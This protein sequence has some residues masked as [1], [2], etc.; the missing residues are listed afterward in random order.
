MANLKLISRPIPPAE[1]MRRLRQALQAEIEPVG[2]EGV[3]LYG[4]PTETWSD[5]NKPAFTSEMG[6]DPQQIAVRVAMQATHAVSAS[7]SVFSLLDEGTDVRYAHMTPDFEAKTTPGSLVSTEGRGGFSHL[8]FPLPGIA[9]RNWT[10]VVNRM[11]NEEM[12]RAVRAGLRKGFAS[13]S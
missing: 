12:D 10:G 7:I 8:D 13:I 5:V 9:A 1:K 11:L 3:K 2:D 6:V 4:Q